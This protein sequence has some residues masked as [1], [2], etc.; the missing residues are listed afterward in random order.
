[1]MIR[2]DAGMVKEEIE[3]LDDKSALSK[4]K[5]GYPHYGQAP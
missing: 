2:I 1:M 5:M 3:Q 4:S